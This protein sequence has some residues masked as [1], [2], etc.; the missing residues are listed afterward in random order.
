M[1]QKEGQFLREKYRRGEISALELESGDIGDDEAYDTESTVAM[2]E[3]DTC[4]NCCEG[5]EIE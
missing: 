5:A 4:V 1:L 3:S 2:S